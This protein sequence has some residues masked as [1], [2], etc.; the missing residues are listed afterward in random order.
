MPKK[1]EVETNPLEKI[2]ADLEQKIKDLN[3]K[4]EELS[5][6]QEVIEQVKP[7]QAFTPQYP[8]PSE[9]R[10][11]VD[12]VL[13][14]E[15]GVDIEYLSDRPEFQ[16]SILVPDKYSNTSPSYRDLMGLDR[17]AK[18]ITN[19]QGLNGVKEYVD[20]VWNN[21]DQD[22]KTKISINRNA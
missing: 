18:V 8:V 20:K 4:V 9:Y 6:P 1:Q 5:K 22:T 10:E 15:F 19:A 2:V 14:K 16:F 3:A 12:T 17:R 7:A 11:V 13:N 21:F